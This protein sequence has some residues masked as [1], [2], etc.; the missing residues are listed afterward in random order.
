MAARSEEQQLLGFVRIREAQPPQVV[1]VG[2][3]DGSSIELRFDEV[4]AIDAMQARLESGRALQ[5]SPGSDGRSLGI[6]LEEELAADEILVL[7]GVRDRAQ[8]PNVMPETRIE[9]AP[10]TWPSD[11]RGLVFLWQSDGVQQIEDPVTGERRSCVLSPTGRAWLDRSFA[12]ELA[13]G[14]FVAND[15][16][17]LGVLNGCRRTN[18]LTLEATLTPHRRA[19]GDAMARIITFSGGRRSR[20]LTL[21]QIDDRLVFRLRTATTG[22]NADQPQLELGRIPIGQPSH[23]LITYTAGRLVAY[24]DG[25]QVLTTN[26]LQDGFFHWQPRPLVFGNEWQANFPWFGALEGVAIYD[27]ALGADEAFENYRRYAELRAELPRVDRIRLRARLVQR[28]AI[29]SL[30]EIAPYREALAVFAYEIEELL[31]G[32]LPEAAKIGSPLRVAHRVLAD[33]EALPVSRRATS[34][35]VELMIEPFLDHQ[36]LESL[37]LSDTLPVTG[38]PLFF[39]SQIEP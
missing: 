14:A 24:I 17:V 19:A 9:I 33:G 32:E 10:P 26:A 23:V 34:R 37:Y 2:V 38:A 4:I 18:E 22:Q 36:Q 30:Q 16:T 5:W 29:P 27:R 28:S 13:G 25:R 20:N 12:M 1:D 15:E 7:S 39:S 21:G 6:E 3:Q 31:D 35:S 8:R 11:P